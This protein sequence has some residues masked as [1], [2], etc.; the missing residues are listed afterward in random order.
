MYKSLEIEMA[1]NLNCTF[2]INAILYAKLSVY[3]KSIKI[4]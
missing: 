3:E 1:E 2:V 4:L